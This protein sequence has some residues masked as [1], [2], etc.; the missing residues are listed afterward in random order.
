MSIKNPIWLLLLS[1]ILAVFGYY[2]YIPWGLVVGSF[3][4]Y[5]FSIGLWVEM[6]EIKTKERLKDVLDPKI[7]KIEKHTLNI[8]QKIDSEE[9]IKGILKRKRNEIIEWL[10][11]F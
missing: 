8:F 2:E 1:I 11:R 4:I 10:S 6:D 9:R 7:E 3:I 5:I